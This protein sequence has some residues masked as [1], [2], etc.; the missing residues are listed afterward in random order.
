M[1]KSTFINW[2]IGLY[3]QFNGF[4]HEHDSQNCTPALVIAVNI[5]HEY[6]I[7]SYWNGMKNMV[8]PK[9]MSCKQQ[10]AIYSFLPDIELILIRRWGTRWT[11]EGVSC[12]RCIGNDRIYHR[13]TTRKNSWIII[14]SPADNFLLYDFGIAMINHHRSPMALSFYFPQFFFTSCSLTTKSLAPSLSFMV[15]KLPR[16]WSFRL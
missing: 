9:I 1:L 6:N 14:L 10:F 13:F 4:L 11:T 8:F 7:N 5:L 12:S 3:T 16:G 15:N 2:C